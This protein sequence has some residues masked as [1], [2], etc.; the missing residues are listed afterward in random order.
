[1]STFL[2]VAGGWHGGWSWKR[3]A[4]PLRNA[5]H[6]VYTPTLTGLGDRAHL[7]S[8]AVDLETHVA[9]I[10]GVIEWEDLQDVTL[11][12]HSYGGMVITAVADRMP[13]RIARLGVLRRAVAARRRVCVRCHRRGGCPERG[14]CPG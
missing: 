7:M 4:G 3:V 12:G 2:F 8:D 14:R 6:D 5:G 13:E 9:D 11:I 1:M 10:M